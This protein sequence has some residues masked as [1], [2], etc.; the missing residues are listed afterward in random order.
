MRNGLLLSLFLAGFNGA[1]LHF[2]LSWAFN[3][4]NKVFFGVLFGGMGWKMFTLG[5][6]AFFIFGNPSFHLTVTLLTF[7][8]FSMLF[9]FISIKFLPKNSHGF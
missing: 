2:L 9:T 4:S 1:M 6:T 3:K 5:L 7:V 8:F